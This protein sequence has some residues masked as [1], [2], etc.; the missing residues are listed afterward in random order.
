MKHAQGTDLCMGL[1]RAL[2]PPNMSLIIGLPMEDQAGGFQPTRMRSL[3]TCFN[4]D[5]QNL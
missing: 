4:L 3:R 5:S 1:Q 2:A